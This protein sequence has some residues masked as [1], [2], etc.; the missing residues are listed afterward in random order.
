MK[1]HCVS[2]S[3]GA[4]GLHCV[5]LQDAGPCM[6]VYRLWGCS[7]PVW[8]VIRASTHSSFSM[9]VWCLVVPRF[10]PDVP[11]SYFLTL[12]MNHPLAP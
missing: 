8:W 11:I 5:W 9:C 6:F 3:V 7:L 10:F 2:E 4:P 12:L 1:C